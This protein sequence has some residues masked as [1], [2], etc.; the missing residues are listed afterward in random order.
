MFAEKKDISHPENICYLSSEMIRWYTRESAMNRQKYYW[1][2][3]KPTN[4]PGSQLLCWHSTLKVWQIPICEAHSPAPAP[5]ISPVMAHAAVMPRT[6]SLARH[7]RA[8]QRDRVGAAQNIGPLLNVMNIPVFSC[9]CPHQSSIIVMLLLPLLPESICIMLMTNINCFLII[10]NQK[11]GKD[12]AGG[13]TDR[14]MGKNHIRADQKQTVTQTYWLC[15]FCLTG[16]RYFL[17]S[18]SVWSGTGE[19]SG[20]GGEQEEGEDDGPV[21]ALWKLESDKNKT[22]KKLLCHQR[23]NPLESDA[24]SVA[25]SILV[26]SD[27]VPTAKWSQSFSIIGGRHA[28]SD[29]F[30]N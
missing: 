16:P 25:T 29:G 3:I 4:T 28:N 14:E 17:R 19:I 9:S 1:F 26:Q 6:L 12:L 30:I 7:L 8:E 5:V 15:V 22:S 21:P 23:L 27:W 2:H 10:M 18:V 11:Y 20:G 13:E 24:R